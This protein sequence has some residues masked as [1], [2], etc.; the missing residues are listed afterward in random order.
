MLA[1]EAYT[2][3]LVTLMRQLEND[4]IPPNVAVQNFWAML[5]PPEQARFSK[6]FPQFM[7]YV[8]TSAA[9]GTGPP[10]ADDACTLR[11]Y[12]MPPSMTAEDLALQF[13]LHGRLTGTSVKRPTQG[14]AGAG[15][16]LPRI[17][18]VQF[19]DAAQA[20]RAQAALDGQVIAGCPIQVVVG[21]A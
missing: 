14:T 15:Q 1:A 7:H 20:A 6:E 10:A 21:A 18:F 2:G 4:A 9:P 12:N 5:T 19:A 8:T 16:P 13:G 17:G 3:K 11:V